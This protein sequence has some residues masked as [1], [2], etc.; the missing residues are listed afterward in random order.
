MKKLTKDTKVVAL[1]GAGISAESGIRTF[2]ESGGLWENHRIE[3][4]A[5]WNGFV[6]DPLKV[7]QFYRERWQQSLQVQPN[8]AHIAL[9]EL[10][11][12]L[13]D[14]FSLITQ[15]VDGLHTRAGSKH[16]LEMHGSL[17]TCF[18]TEC[19]SRYY[20][21]DIPLGQLIPICSKCG[22]KLRPNIVWFGE[23]PH[24]LFEIENKLKT[25]DVFI[26]IGTSGVVYP[27]AGFVMTA[28]LMGAHTI[29]VN[30]DVPENMS[31]IDEYY[32]GKSGTILPPLI[33][34]WISE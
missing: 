3:D 27:A 23:I 4:I 2:R 15:N 18:C 34:T 11:E 22:A 17:G 5:T 13:H 9:L 30:L 7:W 8:P 10:E 26:I 33:R 31:F 14:N 32:A 25:C 24:Y 19:R 1:T 28:K 20:M 21:A 6:K 12:Y 29:A 16:V